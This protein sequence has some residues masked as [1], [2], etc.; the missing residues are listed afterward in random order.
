MVAINLLVRKEETYRIML[1]W[2]PTKQPPIID[3]NR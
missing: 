3:A 1:S 2:P